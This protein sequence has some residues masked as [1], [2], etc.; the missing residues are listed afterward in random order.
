MFKS[1][2]IILEE[3]DIIIEVHKGI[4]TLENIIRYRKKQ[5]ED[6]KFSP[7]FHILMDM[8]NVIIAGKP[9]NVNDYVSF[10]L[11][12]KDMMGK[13][14]IAVLTSTPNQVFYTTLFEQHSEHLTQK[15]RTFS[16]EEAAL[17]WLNVNITKP[18]LNKILQDLRKEVSA[19]EDLQ[20]ESDNVR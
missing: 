17:Q 16:T 15:T 20:Q 9:V 12:N 11:K 2:Y 1:T 3:S 10:Y 13:R 5:M 8:R 18:E 6:H 19:I 14:R 7:D 4:L